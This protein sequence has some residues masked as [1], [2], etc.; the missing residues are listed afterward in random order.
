MIHLLWIT[1]LRSLEVF[2]YAKTV[3]GQMEVWCRYHT[4]IENLI[5]RARDK[6]RQ[7]KTTLLLHFTYITVDR[8]GTA[9]S[10]S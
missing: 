7:D 5:G 1:P 10:K 8:P 6:T 4:K 3:W 2:V 9:G